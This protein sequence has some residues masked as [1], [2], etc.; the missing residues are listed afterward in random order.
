MHPPNFEEYSWTAVK[1]V[2]G[3]PPVCNVTVQQCELEYSVAQV[4]SV[5]E[6]I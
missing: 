4:L 1:G 3:G 5:E 2:S 6:K